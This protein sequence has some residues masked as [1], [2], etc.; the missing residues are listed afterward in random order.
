MNKEDIKIRVQKILNVAHCD[1]RK[2]II[3]DYHDRIAFAC[4]YCGDS[5]KDP[6]KKRGNLYFKNMFYICYN[7]GC[8]A[9]L[10]KFFSD[11]GCQLDIDEKLQLMEYA[12]IERVRDSKDLDFF[13]DYMDKLI[14]VD[15]FI[16]WTKDKALRIFPIKN[17]SLVDRYLKWRKITNRFNMYEG[18]WNNTPIIAILNTVGNKL[19]SLQIRNVSK[20][21]KIYKFYN[22]SQLYKFLMKKEMKE[23]EA[24]IYDK[25]S[26]YF[27]LFQ[28]DFTKPVTV[29]ESFLDST[30]FQNSVALVG[31][32]SDISL[33]LD[34]SINVKWVFDNDP[35]DPK[36]PWKT[37]VGIK[38]A[39]DLLKNDQSIFLWKKFIK[40]N[41]LDKYTKDINQAV[42]QNEDIVPVLNDYFSQDKLDLMFL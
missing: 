40:D 21:K 35:L 11:F 9:S 37:P 28:V 34:N 12:K 13:Q 19:I 14:P 18:T 30:F 39:E 38:K 1:D 36:K 17:G 6:Y 25:I 41:S 42:M 24:S 4:P 26:H 7:D 10:F 16:E 8:K 31:I 27:K 20:D 29:V 32:N 5:H 23:E 33:F 15:E 22:F 3:K 2:K